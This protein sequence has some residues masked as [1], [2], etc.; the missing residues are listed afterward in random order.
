MIITQNLA[1]VIWPD[2]DPIGKT[3]HLWSDPQRAATVSGVVGNL[4]ERS[5]EGPYRFKV[6]LSIYIAPPII[7]LA[8]IAHT[9]G[10]ETSVVPAMRA[11]M[12][13]IDRELPLLGIQ[14]IEESV[15]NNI[16]RRGFILRL[17][18][19][20][21]L[22]ALMLAATGIYGVMAYSVEQRTTEIGIR[23]A[24]GAHGTGILRLIVLG[25]LKLALLGIAVGWLVS[26]LLGRWISSMLHGV[27][28][29]DAGTYAGVAVIMTG[30]ALLSFVI[31][32]PRATRVDPVIS[33]RA[34]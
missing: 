17:L 33:L 19:V 20:F 9:T 12:A 26:V 6:F 10:N 13:D 15:A 8:L 1:E 31:P 7:D 5:L 28:A 3:M 29:T 22:V 27:T 16:S 21:A 4:R 2:Q 11:I 24:L 14:T 23:T 18:S 32:T 25:G 34:E 30:T